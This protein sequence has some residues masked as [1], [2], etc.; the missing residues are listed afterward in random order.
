MSPRVSSAWAL[1]LFIARGETA[2]VP[3]CHRAWQKGLLLGTGTSLRLQPPGSVPCCGMRGGLRAPCIA[4]R[5]GPLRKGLSLH[6]EKRTQPRTRTREVGFENARGAGD[7][8][9][10]RTCRTW[11]VSGQHHRG[12]LQFPDQASRLSCQPSLSPLVGQPGGPSPAPQPVTNGHAPQGW[13]TLTGALWRDRTFP[14]ASSGRA[15][16]PACRSWCRPV[17]HFCC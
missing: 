5:L 7:I 11:A 16:V 8:I 1:E 14:K 13:A 15:H 4:S 3:S 17:S 2:A 10:E 12:R 9:D 6:V